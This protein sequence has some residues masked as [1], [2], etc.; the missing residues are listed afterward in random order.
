VPACLSVFCEFDVH[1]CTNVAGAGSARATW[2]S[3]VTVLTKWEPPVLFTGAQLL[4][5]HSFG[6]F[7]FAVEK[8]V[9]RQRGETRNAK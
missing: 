8:K 2:R 5:R 6:Y 9:T 7:S 4:W 3:M 1:G